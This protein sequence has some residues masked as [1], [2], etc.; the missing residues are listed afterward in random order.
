MAGLLGLADQQ[1]GNLVAVT[2]LVDLA[3]NFCL[4]LLEQRPGAKLLA[5]RDRVI[6]D[7]HHALLSLRHEFAG[8]LVH[9][10]A[11]GEPT[12]GHAEKRSNRNRHRIDRKGS[13]TTLGNRKIRDQRLGGLQTAS[14]MPTPIRHSRIWTKF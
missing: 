4:R 8:G 9:R 11:P 10:V 14:P 13:A 2:K 3:G 12:D 1:E 5:H 6:N 7:E